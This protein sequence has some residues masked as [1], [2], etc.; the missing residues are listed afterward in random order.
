MKF[1]NTYANLE[2]ISEPMG[3]RARAIKSSSSEGFASS[4]R[5]AY[6]PSIRVRIYIFSSIALDSV[7]S[8]LYLNDNLL[9]RGAGALSKSGCVQIV[10]IKNEEASVSQGESLKT[11]LV[12]PEILFLAG[13]NLY[14]RSCRQRRN[15]YL[16]DA[17]ENELN[18]YLLLM[19]LGNT[20]V[21]FLSVVFT[22]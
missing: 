22:N 15:A 7:K 21:L 8:D 16:L 10:G 14:L 20:L 5:Y 2:P 3:N 18:I 1:G 17:L 11:N 9:H 4:L 12:K 19:G 13:I 6:S